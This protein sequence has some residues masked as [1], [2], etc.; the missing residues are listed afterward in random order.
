MHRKDCQCPQCDPEMASLMKMNSQQYAGWL[1]LKTLRSADQLRAA[2]DVNRHE[3]PD[4]YE[5]HLRKLRAAQPAPVAHDDEARLRSMADFRDS[6][7]GMA[8]TAQ[9]Q[10]AAALRPK[11]GDVFANPPDPYAEALRLR[12]ET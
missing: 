2:E 1:T 12:K 3:P 11:T 8:V 4:P 7:Y 6:V 10:T 5:P 9:L